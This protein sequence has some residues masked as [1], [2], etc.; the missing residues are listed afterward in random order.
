MTRLLAIGDIHGCYK[1]LVTLETFV[2][3]TPADTLVTLGDYVNRGPDSRRVLDWLISKD[4]THT[5]VPL[6]GNHDL[7]MDRARE[8][9]RQFDRW[10][11]R[12]GDRTLRSYRISP[13]SG[14]PSLQLV[15][16]SHWEFISRRLLSYFESDD[17]LFVHASYDAELPMSEQSDKVLYWKKFSDPPRHRSGKRVVCGHS[18]QKSGLPLQNENAICIDTWACGGGWL[19]CLDVHSKQ[20]WQA[21]QR[22]E[23]RRFTLDELGVSDPG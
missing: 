17:H 14:Q 16:R 18:S 7:M 9:R 20:L 2:E 15:P 19:S 11:R 3:F 1:A 6:R 21:N 8:S 5:L 13:R 12:G 22:G 23:T 4:Q 10:L